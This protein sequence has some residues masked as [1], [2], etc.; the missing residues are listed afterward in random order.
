[1][2]DPSA[3]SPTTLPPAAVDVTAYRRAVEELASPA[4]FQRL[5][6]VVFVVAS[7]LLVAGLAAMVWMTGTTAVAVAVASGLAGLGVLLALLVVL[8]AQL[9]GRRRRRLGGEAAALRDAA[10]VGIRS[11]LAS[12]GY[13]VPLETA[14]A[15]LDP[16]QLDATVPLVHDS[17]IAARLWRPAA[18]DERVFLEPYL[19][20]GESSSA[21]PVLPAV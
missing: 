21:L 16:V 2:S 4:P 13:T 10:A 9:A 14:S 3:V 15:W 6:L 8:P 12:I 18:T 5:A 19:R 11:R 17:V 1:M 20:Q 7:V